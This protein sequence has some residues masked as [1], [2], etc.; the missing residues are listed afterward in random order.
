MTNKE[1]MADADFGKACG[2]AGVPETARQASK[3]RMGVGAAYKAYSPVV[4]ERARK[5]AR[6]ARDRAKRAEKRVKV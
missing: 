1:F 5:D 3:F 2:M 4:L 6:N